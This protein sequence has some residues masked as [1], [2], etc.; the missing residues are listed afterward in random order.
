MKAWLRQENNLV[1]LLLA[2][3]FIIF[4]GLAVLR[5]YQF[6][7]QAWDLGIFSQSF[8]NTVQ[9]RFMVNTIEELPNHFGV[10]FSP[11]LIVLVPGYWLFS[12]PYYLLIIQTLALAL[13]AWPLYRLAKRILPDRWPLLMTIGY[14]LY[15]SLHWVNLFDFHPIAFIIPFLL[16]AIYFFEINKL[17]WSAAFLC[18][19]AATQEDAI[20][21]VLFAGLYF[22]LRQPEVERSGV[23][24][25]RLFGWLVM[26]AAAVY[27]ILTVK[28]IMPGF[29]GGLLR[30]DRYSELG[31]SFG[32]IGLNLIADPGLFLAT[33]V[34]P[35]KLVYLLYLFL[36]LVFLPFFNWRA[37]LMIIPGL[38]ENL[39]TS[40]SFQQSGFYQYD[41]VVIPGLWLGTIFGLFNVLKRWPARSKVI[42]M[43][44]I[45]FTVGMFLVRSP[46]NPF[47]FPYFLFQASDRA[48][49]FRQLI[50]LVPEGISVAA[51]TNLVPH[52][53]D[54]KKIYMLGHEPEYVD[55]VLADLGDAFGFKDKANFEAYLQS[56]VANPAYSAGKFRDRYLM[57]VKKGI[58]LNLED[59][60]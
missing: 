53:A 32:E 19:A 44:F 55:L 45:V 17:W 7:T 59:I 48:I 29:G 57:I 8:W 5:H 21:T 33:L 23:S 10:H 9:G 4:A 35:A 20:L 31:G 60:N 3:Y 38:L 26:I 42:K 6:Q 46:I 2:V 34:E 30:L 51:Q 36:P 54:R 56:Y 11:W 24:K 52:L 41:S 12:S 49:A 13:G 14:L 37:L 15:P 40:F 50:K 18:L 58:V 28:L 47:G 1:W 25:R 22:I 16:A 39:L 27:F 43:V